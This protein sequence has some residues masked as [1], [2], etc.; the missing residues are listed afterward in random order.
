MRFD[1]PRRRVPMQALTRGI[2]LLPMGNV[3]QND[4][5]FAELSNLAADLKY[6]AA[7]N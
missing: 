6:L 7:L 4:N 3:Q 1:E 2:W 5:R